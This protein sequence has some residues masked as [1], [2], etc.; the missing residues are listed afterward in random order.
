MTDGT[1]IY[2]PF[3]VISNNCPKAGVFFFLCL[4]F[5]H[6]SHHFIVIRFNVVSVQVHTSRPCVWN[7]FADFL[8]IFVSSLSWD[9][10]ELIGV[11]RSSSRYAEV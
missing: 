3:C 9:N 10:D 1:S 11:Q 8:Q 4:F 5:I 7:A 6:A 2:F